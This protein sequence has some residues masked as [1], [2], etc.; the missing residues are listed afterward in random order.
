MKKNQTVN[1]KFNVPKPTELALT[2]HTKLVLLK[3]TY[4]HLG[5]LLFDIA[6]GVTQHPQE[7]VHQAVCAIA[8]LND[9]LYSINETNRVDLDAPL[10]ELCDDAEGRYKTSENIADFLVEE[11]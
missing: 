2:S 7:M 6:T 8:Y 10:R 3:K 9:Y 1:F 4:D 11:E 5:W